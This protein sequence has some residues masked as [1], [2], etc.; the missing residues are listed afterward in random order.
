MANINSFLVQDQTRFVKL[1][2]WPSFAST[3]DYSS[4][5]ARFAPS[6]RAS[7]PLL[8]KPNS[9]ETIHAHRFP[10]LHAAGPRIRLR[11]ARERARA[12]A[13]ESRRLRFKWMSGAAAVDA[14]VHL[15]RGFF[16]KVLYFI[17]AFGLLVRSV[18][19][20]GKRPLFFYKKVIKNDIS[21]RY[22]VPT[23]LKTRMTDA[24]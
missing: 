23:R 17:I 6:C 1:N 8:S 2:L 10:L 14:R 24:T 15:R 3:G 5:P 4:F 18:S 13:K 9:P 11:S 16:Y 20:F 19:V 12:S 22:L 7:S 21:S